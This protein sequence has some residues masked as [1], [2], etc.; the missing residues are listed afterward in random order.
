MGGGA[1]FTIHRTRLLVILA[2]LLLALMGSCAYFAHVARDGSQ[3]GD[4][5][6]DTDVSGHGDTDAQA[7]PADGDSPKTPL[8]AAPSAARLGVD[9]GSVKLLYPGLVRGVPLT[10]DNPFGFGIDVHTIK[11]SSHGTSS[12]PAEFLDL[13]TY[14]LLGPRIDAA[15]SARTATRIALTQN[16]PEACQRERFSIRVT[17]TAGRS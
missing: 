10:I 14:D 17:V 9:V 3:P 16:A 2:V 15:S 1:M 5:A 8:P 11:V 13:R 6:P 12:C 7:G 4:P